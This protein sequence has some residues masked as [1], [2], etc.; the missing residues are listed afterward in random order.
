MI[1]N[2][3]FC[4][5]SLQI[6]GDNLFFFNCNYQS[7]NFKIFYKELER[8]IRLSYLKI[9]L[10]DIDETRK[11][12][13]FLC[14]S[15][16]VEDRIITDMKTSLTCACVWSYH[17]K[18]HRLYQTLQK[19]HETNNQI[20]QGLNKLRECLNNFK[21]YESTSGDLYVYT[22]NDQNFLL[23][24]EPC[25]DED[26]RRGSILSRRPSYASINDTEQNVVITNRSSTHGLRNP[27]GGGSVA[28]V[29][30]PQTQQK[31][32]PPEAVK[33]SVYGLEEPDDEMKKDLCKTLQSE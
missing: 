9:I 31:S 15:D 4:D 25:C 23:K 22:R 14:L 12:N 29:Q 19:V 11:W 28:Q 2:S 16:L 18:L 24:L 10:K 1:K 32:N 21:I 8:Q 33:L 6:L 7:I 26:E 17:F 27:S 3:K 5:C 30:T 13:N 20:S